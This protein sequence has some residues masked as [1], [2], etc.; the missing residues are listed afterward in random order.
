M[1][2]TLCLVAHGRVH[3]VGYRAFVLSRAREL[4]LSGWVRNRPDG[5]V[6]AE[7]QG[8][9]S[10]LD[11]LAADLEHGPPLSHVQRLDVTFIDRPAYHG[12]DVRF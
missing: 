8:E 2:R 9:D 4:G 10:D 6:E 1:T 3:G 11:R 12:F 7:A 5:T